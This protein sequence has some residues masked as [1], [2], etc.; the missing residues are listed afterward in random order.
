MMA[1][2]L[3]L[4]LLHPLRDNCL[5]SQFAIDDIL[6][7]TSARQAHD[8]LVKHIDY[9]E[10]KHVVVGWVYVMDDGTQ[11]TQRAVSPGS[12]T[13]LTILKHGDIS[14]AAVRVRCRGSR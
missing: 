3:A 6:P 2:L 8:H 13:G 10:V 7:T 14:S 4:A 11:L 1:A 9:I 12:Y 5:G